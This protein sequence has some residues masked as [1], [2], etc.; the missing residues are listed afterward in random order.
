LLRLDRNRTEFGRLA[1]VVRRFFEQKQELVR[2]VEERRQAEERARHDALHDSLTGLPNRAL[3]MDRLANAL[4]RSRRWEGSA[5]AVLFV[6]LDRF[7]VIN[8]SLGHMRGDQLLRIAARRVLSCVREGDL[9]ARLSGDEFGVL[10][11]HVRDAA[12]PVAVTDRMQR[13]LALPYD[14]DGHEACTTAS[15]GIALSSTGYDRPEELLRDAD[16][17]MYQAKSTGHGR[18]VVFHD[19]LGTAVLERLSLESDL[20]RAV[21]RDELRVH[22]Q[23][24]VSMRTRQIVGFEALVRWQ[25]PV[26]GLLSP[27]EFVPLAE[28]T[29]LIAAI[30]LWVLREACRQMRRLDARWPAAGALTLAVNVSGKHFAEPGLVEHVEQILTATGFPPRRLR[31]EITESAI[32][33]N[34][35]SACEALVRLDRLGVELCLD[36]F[37]TGYSS[38][39]YLHMLPVRSLKIDRRFSSRM[40]DEHEFEIVRTIVMLARKLGMEVV[41]EGVETT[42]QLDRL[43]SLECEFAQGY[44]F[45]RPLEAAAAEALVDDRLAPA[46]AC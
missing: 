11:E 32:I 4:A 29:G 19:A 41:A 12:T 10:L 38:L 23:P 42:Q 40:L 44:L 37:G 13:E 35:E 25:H 6:D 16:T 1:S 27:V 34:A 8:D 7:K 31:L 5:F 46:V 21:D 43:S 33:E 18:T 2:E 3:F 45:S 22:Y 24:I 36:D 9:V 20:R 39:S 28:E 30:D 15:V 17:A 14:L 26:R